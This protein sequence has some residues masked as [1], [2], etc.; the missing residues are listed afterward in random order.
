MAHLASSGA[1]AFLDR[2][3]IAYTYHSHP[4][5]F[6]VEESLRLVPELPGAKTKNLFL[7]NRKGTRHLLLITSHDKRVNLDAL[8]AAVGINGLSFASPERLLKHL[9]VPPGAVSLLALVNDEPNSVEVVVD[10][11]VWNAEAVQCHPLDNGATVVI[12]RDDV[13]RFVEATGHSA[14]VIDV[15]VSP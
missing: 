7:R 1:L 10:A 15:P 5:V 9:G 6:T 12:P 13:R 14:R 2:R 4:P 8:S 3:G 11:A